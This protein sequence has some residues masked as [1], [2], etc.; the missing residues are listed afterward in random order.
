[1]RGQS[2]MSIISRGV[3][4]SMSRTRPEYLDAHASDRLIFRK[5]PDEEEDE[6]EEDKKDED[7]R[8]EGEEDDDQHGG[9]SV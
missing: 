6:D 8:E 9:F 1:M 3:P 2:S 4:L 7:D 5:E